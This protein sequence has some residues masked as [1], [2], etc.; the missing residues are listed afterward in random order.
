ME[1]Q[2]AVLLLD[3]FVRREQMQKE[4][5]AEFK[6]RIGRVEFCT[7]LDSAFPLSRFQIGNDSCVLTNALFFPDHNRCLI[8]FRQPQVIHADSFRLL[9]SVK[10]LS[11]KWCEL[12]KTLLDCAQR[13]YPGIKLTEK[14][15][16]ELLTHS[17][18]C[19]WVA[20]D[21]CWTKTKKDAP[22]LAINPLPLNSFDDLKH[23]FNSAQFLLQSSQNLATQVQVT[24][25]FGNFDSL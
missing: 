2:F 22:L 5:E 3:S 13:L 20:A 12:L 4:V 23:Y 11:L 7:G 10:L 15:C 9:I 19:G 25:L 17:A 21:I 24:Q 18:L 1:Q 14:L 6:A 16:G 8:S